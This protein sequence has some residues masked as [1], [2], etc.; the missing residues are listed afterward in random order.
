MQKLHPC[1]RPRIAAAVTPASPRRPF[2]PTQWVAAAPRQC[3]ASWGAVWAWIVLASISKTQPPEESVSGSHRAPSLNRVSTTAA[4]G[5]GSK[6]TLPW[7]RLCEPWAPRSDIGRGKGCTR[8]PR[9]ITPARNHHRS[10]TPTDHAGMHKDCL[11]AQTGQVKMQA[12]L[13]GLDRIPDA[14]LGKVRRRA[15]PAEVLPGN[16]D[17]RERRPT[18]SGTG[19]SARSAAAIV[20]RADRDRRRPIPGPPVSQSI[21]RR[22]RSRRE[23]FLGQLLWPCSTNQQ[24]GTARVP[25]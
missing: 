15:P 19:P 10:T 12:P 13:Q 18:A 14:H 3:K 1:S 11:P 2:H 7:F 4:K 8:P 16:L 9:S 6:Q 5:N 17:L 24:T 25:C 22:I 20:P 21:Q 23:G